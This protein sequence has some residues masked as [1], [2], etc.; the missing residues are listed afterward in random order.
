[1]IMDDRKMSHK[2][3]NST[4]ILLSLLTV[5]LLFWFSSCLGCCGNKEST[6]KLHWCFTA[7]GTKSKLPGMA[8]K[9]ICVQV[10]T[11]GTASSPPSSY[12]TPQIHHNFSSLCALITCVLC[13]KCPWLTKSFRSQFHHLKN[14]PW[15]SQ[16]FLCIYS[17]STPLYLNI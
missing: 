6:I 8:D 12:Y 15:F 14:N 3:W 1:M 4:Q 16:K 10:Q 7:N 9:G 5:F 17:P 11:V 2:F 13:L